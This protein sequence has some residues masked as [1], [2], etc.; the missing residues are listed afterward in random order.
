MKKLTLSAFAVAAA[1]V[2]AAPRQDT[3]FERDLYPILQKA[4]CAGC[5]A[6][7]G[8][9]SATRLRFPEPDAAPEAI[10]AFGRSLAA[11][12]DRSHPEES[13]LLRKPTRRVPH[14]GGMRIKPGSAEETALRAWVER[15]ARDVVPVAA[16]AAPFPAPALAS[17]P[18][19]RRLSHSQYDATVRD[20]LGEAG[21]PSRQF[22][23]EDFVDGFKNQ[24]QASSLSPLQVESYARAAERLAAAAFRDLPTAEGRGLLPCRAAPGSDAA[25]RER[26]V[27]EFGLRA[28]RRPLDA[29]EAAR[30]SAL[31]AA[32]PGFVEGAR[33]VAEAML[34][35]PSFLFQ[36]DPAAV[37]EA[38]SY[39]RASR[40][41]YFLWDSMPDDAL[42]GAAK[43]GEL[44]TPEGFERAA[45]RLLADKRAGSAVDQFVAQWLRFD[46]LTGLLKERRA[47]PQYNRELALAM[48]EETRLF[49]A[50][51]V[52]NDR[53]FMDLFTADY[54]F[55]NPELAA[56]Y[57]VEAPPSGFART[58]YPAGSDR[59]GVLGQGA[60][61]A[62]TS[63]PA[64]TSPTARGLFVRE[65]FLCQR[66]PLPPPGVNM[67][68][69]AVT[70]QRPQT[71]RE[72]LAGHVENES[73]AGCHRL[74]DPIGFGFERFD[75]IGARHEKQRVAISRRTKK[76]EQA[77]T[78]T[79][80]LE[81]DTRGS[82]AGIEGSDFASPR[83]LGRILST[84]RQ[85][86]ECM[87]KQ[88]FR[89]A[90]GRPETPA[91][92]PVLEQ[93][94]GDF[95]RSGFRFKELMVSLLRRTEFP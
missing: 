84:N 23:P 43:A 35:S 38:R 22:P 33:I 63:K 90:L 12:I 68:L 74:I 27:R 46:Q 77:D 15:L 49:V 53:S 6:A 81:L 91:D 94:Y 89:Y 47:F 88:L 86:Q 82:I 87:V 67:N 83:E 51:L 48:T 50:D 28:F 62:L 57:G 42:L 32:Q 8:V 85:C 29:R 52:W 45:R 71:N 72:R 54:T 78:V 80:E 17:R 31:F 66:V 13:P 10:A 41:S 44:D 18:M 56:L 19:L 55:C 11:L 95:R 76:S 64:E 30:Y 58:S 3:D 79:L 59:A 26:F 2:G 7:D 92:A 73:C 36:L 5:H 37:P 61:L 24:I 25:C 40:L 20:L 9:A 21:N 16:S 69:P 39:A 34:Q 60:F 4:G 1:F 65:H 70:E 14:T 75:A 93:V